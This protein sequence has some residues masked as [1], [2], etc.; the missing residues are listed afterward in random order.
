MEAIRV[1]SLSY[2]Y[3]DT[4]QALHE[5]SL[6]I[7]VGSK[8]AMLG[9]NGAGKST[10]VQH[11]N[12]LFLPQSGSVRI[13]GEAVVK[14]NV[15]K[16]RTMVGVVFQNP[17]DQ[18]FSSTVW[19]D[20]CF[21]PANMELSAEEIIERSSEALRAVGMLEWKDKAPYHLSYGQ[22]KRVAVAGVLAMQPDI[23]VLDEPMA[24][25]DPKGKDDLASLLE[26]LHRI[27]KT[28][29]VTTHDVDFAAEWAD[30]VMLLKEGRLIA[31]GGP[32]LLVDPHWVLEGQLHLPKVARPFQMVPELPFGR[33]PLNE[34][35]A[36][37]Y[38]SRLNQAHSRTPV[39]E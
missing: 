24:Y 1:E 22:K 10:L 6:T 33:L 15:R 28:V 2:R 35:E 21:G 20:V 26:I 4:T 12:G 3:P 5:V 7:P 8:T 13:M 23:I 32:E 39:S 29:L 18:V 25:L 34:R 31:S 37:L 11:F 19:E 17:D 16:I 14:S 36:A 27:G 30:R 38:L 9:P